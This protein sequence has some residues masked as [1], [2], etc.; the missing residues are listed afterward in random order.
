VI[1]YQLNGQ[2][3]YLSVDDQQLLFPEGL[4]LERQTG[5]GAGKYFGGLADGST[6]ATAALFWLGAVRDRA[7][8]DGVNFRT[9]A[10]S[11]PFATWADGLDLGTT[12]RTLRRPEAAEADPTPPA[13]TPDGSTATTSPDTSEPQPE[14]TPSPSAAEPISQ[15]SPSSSESAPGSGIS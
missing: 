2:G 9:A 5:L 10:Q 14:P 3:D 11:L 8:R 12:M 4:E 6:Q 15:P 13:A 7:T 1:T